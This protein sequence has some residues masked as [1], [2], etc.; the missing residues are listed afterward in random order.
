[1][2]RMDK[3]IIL[4]TLILL[5]GCGF[6]NWDTTDKALFGGF[7]VQKSIDVAITY[8]CSKKVDC[9]EQNPLFRKDDGKADMGLG[10]VA[11]LAL[12][13]VVYI[14]AEIA[15][16]KWRTPLLWGANIIQFTNNGVSLYRTW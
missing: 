10:I 12:L 8:R 11:S 3:K 2:Y 4:I 14:G 15:G 6:K 16:E 7:V 9:E 1:V 13:P 5:S